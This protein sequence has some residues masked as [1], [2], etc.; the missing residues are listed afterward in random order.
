MRKRILTTATA[1]LALGAAPALAMDMEHGGGL[2]LKGEAGMGLI[3][4][5]GAAQADESRAKF[6]SK[7]DIKFTGEGVTDGGL[8]FGAKAAIE[9][10]GGSKGT[11]TTDAEVHIGG[12]MWKLTVGDLDG[13]TKSL[14]NKL[15]DVGYDGLGVD[16]IAENA[17]DNVRANAAVDLTFGMATVQFTAAAISPDAV[18]G[19]RPAVTGTNASPAIVDPN[20]NLGTKASTLKQKNEWALA[21]TFDVGPVTIGLGANS[22]RQTRTLALSHEVAGVPVDANS[23]DP[24]ALAVNGDGTAVG[25]DRDR[26]GHANSVRVNRE[27]NEVILNNEDRGTVLKARVDA[28]F[29]IFKG[30]LFYS[31]QE[32]KVT[33]TTVTATSNKIQTSKNTGLGVHFGADV[34]EGTTITGVYTQG[35]K[36][37]TNPIVAAGTI[38]STNADGTTSR[39]GTTGYAAK[40]ETLK[41]FGVGVTHSLGGSAKVEAGVAKVDT[42]NTEDQTKFSIGVTMSF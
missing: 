22:G 29:G 9:A 25:E 42:S 30:G 7:F 35:K 34:A 20:Q 26:H 3:W 13:A 36:G 11:S 27:N 5:D 21:A 17:V 40:S 16:D 14:V 28:E 31:Q 39:V 24:A 6:L 15:P 33:E 4:E 19:G 8:T 1:I 18:L 32:V 23:T 12:E 2:S 37:D 41:A 10:R 38:S